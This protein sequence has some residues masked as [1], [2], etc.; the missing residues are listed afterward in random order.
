[1]TKKDVPKKEPKYRRVLRPKPKGSDDNHLYE[2]KLV[3]LAPAG[4]NPD[5]VVLHVQSACLQHPKLSLPVVDGYGLAAKNLTLSS[6][7]GRADYAGGGSMMCTGFSNKPIPKN[8]TEVP[9]I[10]VAP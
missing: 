3:V 2:V 4:L 6:K 1:M 5:D 7:A 9:V 8:A 10:E